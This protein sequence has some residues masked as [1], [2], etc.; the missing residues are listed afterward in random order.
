MANVL[1]IEKEAAICN[2]LATR[3][4]NEVAAESLSSVDRVKERLNDRNFD[5]IICD[6]DILPTER[7]ET[8]RL[9]EKQTRKFPQTKV[10]VF[11]T[12]KS[13]MIAAPLGRALNESSLRWTKP[14]SFRSSVPRADSRSAAAPN[15]RGNRLK[16]ESEHRL[17]F[18]PSGN[19]PGGS[20][21]GIHYDDAC[22]RGRE[23][24][25]GRSHPKN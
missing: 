17:A 9:L 8:F 13:L 21:K 5:L 11:P 3:F 20:G 22:L 12:P 16:N 10:I 14:T 19:E 24:S 7:M 18:D 4:R 15:H 2:A 1:V 6:A 23:Q 25:Q